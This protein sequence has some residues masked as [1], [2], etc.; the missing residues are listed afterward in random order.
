MLAF[1]WSERVEPNRPWSPRA[2]LSIFDFA[3]M[4]AEG[5]VSVFRAGGVTPRGAFATP[6]VPV[7]S[8][9]RL[10]GT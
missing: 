10:D 4:G 6:G 3:G 2:R 1:R 8:P 7:G 5:E 9:G